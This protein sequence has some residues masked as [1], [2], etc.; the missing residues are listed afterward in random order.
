[1][2]APSPLGSG[3]SASRWLREALGRLGQDLVSHPPELLAV[4]AGLRAAVATVLPLAL[5]LGFHA[6]RLGVTVAV[7]A[8]VVGFAALNGTWHTRLG[9]VGWATL[10]A[11]WAAGLGVLG[12]REGLGTI[13]LVAVSG[14]LAAWIGHLSPE[15]AQI[16]ALATNL[17]VVFAGLGLPRSEAGPTMLS[18]FAGGA[19]QWLFLWGWGR[20]Q[21]AQAGRRSLRIAWRALETLCRRPDRAHDLAVARALVVAE[22][23]VSDP[24]LPPAARRRLSQL[25]A[26][27]EQL[28]N[29][30]VSLYLTAPPPAPWTG[31]LTRLL[32]RLG[33]ALAESRLPAAPH[34]APAARAAFEA[35]RA[36]VLA[37]L[38]PASAEALDHTLSHLATILEGTVPAADDETPP[39]AASPRRPT[40]GEWLRLPPPP[41]RRHA[42]RV[43]VTLALAELVAAVGHWPR[44]YW[45]ALTAAVVLRPD[46]YSTVGR[47]VARALGTAAGVAL[48]S[49]WLLW[50]PHPSWV[51]LAALGI[52]AWAAYGTLP[53]NYA[54]F[55]VALSAAIIL[56]LS[57]FEGVAPLVAMGERLE[58][59]A[60]GSGLA[61]AVW[62]LFPT[63]QQTSLPTAF[64]QVI[65]AERQYLEAWLQGRPVAPHRRATRI[66]RTELAAQVAAALTEPPQSPWVKVA[67][68]WVEA[69]HRLSESLMS[70]E[71]QKVPPDP[72]FLTFAQDYAQA[73][74][75]LVQA[76]TAPSGPPPTPP[77]APTDWPH[78]PDQT[79]ALGA[80]AHRLVEAYRTLA[81]HWPAG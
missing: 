65:E 2:Q 18:V 32:A 20:R 58:A 11:A 48:G 1:M 22:T 75:Q 77:L 61:L 55:S 56:L 15:F 23:R 43:A 71:G 40:L 39:A 8:L 76:L 33:R 52:A 50:G 26:D 37:V 79:P 25:L 13:V 45:V 9:T 17:L 57:A 31:P 51:D 47:G 42:V 46:F 38:P 66:R 72:A 70:L 21:L 63:W 60:V 10:W 35:D 30:V 29:T 69:V 14:G 53:Y 59:T 54:L 73:L 12:G 34:W 44:G 81:V 49:A 62:A 64:A 67:P 5:G 6:S 7:G 4:A 36:A 28:R 74:A 3:S 68:I 19:L 80:V 24:A 27:I 78:E 41:A 16:G